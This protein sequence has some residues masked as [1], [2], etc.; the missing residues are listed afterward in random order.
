MIRPH[1]PF[2]V[3]VGVVATLVGTAAAEPSSTST[4]SD[5]TREAIRAAIANAEA[6]GQKTVGVF[7]PEAPSA[8]PHAAISTVM[9]MNRCTGGCVINGGTADDS[10]TFTSQ[11]PNAGTHPM[12]EFQEGGMT[13]AAADDAW[14]ELVACVKEVYSPYGV[15]VTD[16]PPTA[17][18]YHMAIV[19]GLPEDIGL[20]SNTG[21]V[22]ISTCA[23]RENGISF[24]FANAEGGSGTSRMLKLCWYVAQESAHN[25]GLAYHAWKFTADGRSACN[26]PMT[27]REDCGG[28]KFFRNG[29]VSCGDFSENQPACMCGPSQN[30]HL[31]LLAV[32]GEGT[33]TYGKPNAAVTLPVE[34]GQLGAVVG[35]QAG[36]K[37][38][39]AKLEL[40]VN[41]FKWAEVTGAPFGPNG[42]ANPSPYTIPVP[43]NLPGGVVELVARAYDDLGDYADSPVVMATKGA[44]CA[45][46][47]SCAAGQKCEAGKCFW[48]PPSGEIGDSCGF[49]QACLSGKC[50]PTAEDRICTQTCAPGVMGSCPENFD[51]LQTSA[52]NFCYLPPEEGGCCSV[53]GGPQAVY[54]HGALSAL[55][56]GFLVF[57]R[58]RR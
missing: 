12:G 40:L 3:A 26:D 19:A 38:G 48:D 22:A 57:R 58:R 1:A 37:R 20:S 5:P 6:N 53:G 23:P 32:F 25:F 41:G 9:Y 52:G 44:P 13:G 36:S 30:S 42:Q 27:Y 50:S 4:S 56:F 47:D 10:R 15:Q 18:A 2:F 55:V 54:V 35:V 34:G 43:S 33:P 16:Q 49:D 31:K 39:I 24:T 14:N 29:N 21:G 11:I 17:A 51:C 7:L 28:Q 8:L 46:A 45:S